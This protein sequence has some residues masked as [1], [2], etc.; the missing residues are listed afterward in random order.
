M[1]IAESPLEP[2]PVRIGLAEDQGEGHALLRQGVQF[3]GGGNIRL[4]AAQVHKVHIAKLPA[5]GQSAGNG[6]HGGHPEPAE[7][8]SRERPE[9]R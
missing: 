7:S 3:G 2:L 1:L 6:E 8:S 9:P 5:Q 4:A